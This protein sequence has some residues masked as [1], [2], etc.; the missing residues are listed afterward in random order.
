MLSATFKG[1]LVC[2]YCIKEAMKIIHSKFNCIDSYY[3]IMATESIFKMS[4]YF[5][6]YLL[7]FFLNLE[8]Q[9]LCTFSHSLVYLPFSWL[10]CILFL[11]Y[12]WASILNVSPK[13]SALYSLSQGVFSRVP[14]STQLV[15]QDEPLGLVT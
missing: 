6:I 4:K 3:K 9:Y 12:L 8:L 1:K 7:V 5:N 13:L 15:L 2:S 11:S 14:R 10:I